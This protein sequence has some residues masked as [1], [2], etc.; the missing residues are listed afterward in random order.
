M[1]PTPASPAV[2]A[3]VQQLE[4]QQLELQLQLQHEKHTLITFAMAGIGSRI[5]QP[6]VVLA[7]EGTNVRARPML[8]A[9][10]SAPGPSQV[11]LMGA[12]LVRLDSSSIGC[13]WDKAQK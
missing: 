6:E 10:L 9:R 3:P 5:T 4:L 1:P 12:S 2:R 13:G 7:L 11:T 8:I